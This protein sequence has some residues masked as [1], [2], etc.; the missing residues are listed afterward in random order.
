MQI[1]INKKG[2]KIFFI[3]L[4]LLLIGLYMAWNFEH[5]LTTSYSPDKNNEL[6]IKYVTPFSFGEHKIKLLY[7]P[8]KLF[9]LRKNTYFAY[10]NNDGMALNHSNYKIEWINDNTVKIQ[11]IGFN[12]MHTETYIIN[13]RTNEITKI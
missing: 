8:K 10:L 3:T 12:I 1:M 13:F 5:T 7:G 4:I 9:C 2:I 11:L 6:V